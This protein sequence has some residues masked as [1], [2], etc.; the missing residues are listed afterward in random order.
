MNLAPAVKL[1]PAAGRTTRTRCMS[2]SKA[3]GADAVVARRVGDDAG[4]FDAV[5]CTRSCRK[6]FV[7][8]AR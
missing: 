7:G 5:Y 8:G 1:L 3:L 6:T 4:D 2:C